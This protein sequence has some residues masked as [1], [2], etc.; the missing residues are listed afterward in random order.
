M[1]YVAVRRIWRTVKVIMIICYG[2]ELAGFEV[3]E[4]K[5]LTVSPQ[6]LCHKRVKYCATNEI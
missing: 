3:A 4:L 2:D 5:Q 6:T 1:V